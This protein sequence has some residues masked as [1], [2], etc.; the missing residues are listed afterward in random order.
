[1]ARSGKVDE[2]LLDDRIEF[3]Q[4]QDFFQAVEKFQG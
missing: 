3:F 2:F 1:V 4:Y